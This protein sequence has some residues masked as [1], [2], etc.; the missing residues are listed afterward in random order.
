MG[1]VAAD[2]VEVGSELRPE[3]NWENRAQS[4]GTSILGHALEPVDPH[5]Q[6]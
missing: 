3:E 4:L 2:T 5:P 6:T 1:E